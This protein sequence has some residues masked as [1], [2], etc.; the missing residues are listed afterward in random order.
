[1]GDPSGKDLWILAREK[2]LDAEALARI[3]TRAEELGF[4]TGPLEMTDQE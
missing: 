4:E 2:A 1:M 3:T